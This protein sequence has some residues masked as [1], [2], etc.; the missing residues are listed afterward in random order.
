M[1]KYPPGYGSHW[2]GCWR[3]AAHWRCCVKHAE[4]LEAELATCRHER[5]ALSTDV[6]VATHIMRSVVAQFADIDDDCWATM[7]MKV[8]V[9]ACEEWLRNSQDVTE[10]DKPL[11]AL[12]EKLAKCDRAV[13]ALVEERDQCRDNCVDFAKQ[14]NG[15]RQANRNLRRRVEQCREELARAEERLAGLEYDLSNCHQDLSASVIELTCGHPSVCRQDDGK[16]AWCE[17]LEQA[18]AEGYR[19]GVEAGIEDALGGKAA[20]HYQ[21]ALKA[22]GAA[23]ER[24]RCVGIVRKN[25]VACRGT[26]VDG[27]EQ[28]PSGEG[29]V[30]RRCEYCGR[31]IDTIREAV[32]EQ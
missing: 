17:S 31:T 32:D 29:W 4:E 23:E 7:G 18:R 27:Q 12:I 22:E 21:E 14:I 13:D 24:E 8:A 26:G 9:E 1:T 5:D 15:L 16:C 6:R 3:N 28:H 20:K 25:C 19:D 30:P 2:E 10:L 11:D